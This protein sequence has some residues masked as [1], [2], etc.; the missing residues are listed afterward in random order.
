ME[1]TVGDIIPI[2]KDRVQRSSTSPSSRPDILADGSRGGLCRH[3]T[4]PGGESPP[5]RGVVGGT[6]VR[7]P[8]E[9]SL[10]KCWGWGI[11][12]SPTGDVDV[13][14]GF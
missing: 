3:S 2:A 7:Q 1:R 6:G 12:L 4:R 8:A 11:P 14:G 9:A 10:Q 13:G 5:S